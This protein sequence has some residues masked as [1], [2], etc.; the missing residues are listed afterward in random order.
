M[1]VYPKHIINGDNIV[2][3]TKV[4]N[5]SAMCL[6]VKVNLYVEH[7]KN[8]YKKWILKD[9]LFL[10][11]PKEN[12]QEGIMERYY[13][14]KT[15][16]KSLLGKYYCILSIKYLKK[17]S[18]SLTRKNAY[19][20]IEKVNIEKKE[21]FLLIYNKSDCSVPINIFYINKNYLKKIKSLEV[22]RMPKKNFLYLKYANNDILL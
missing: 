1:S 3:H 7:N 6:P 14:F 21:N 2:I 12:N 18:F 17:E 13:M 15:N 11:P 22:I 4:S 19:F 20:Y 9:K 10:V 5:Y 8:K 16:K